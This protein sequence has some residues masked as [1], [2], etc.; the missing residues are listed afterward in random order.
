MDCIHVVHWLMAAVATRDP[1][2]GAGSDPGNRHPKQ[3]L[4]ADRSRYLGKAERR[5]RVDHPQ[6]GRHQGP[7]PAKGATQ[8]MALPSC[9]AGQGMVCQQSRH[10]WDVME[11]MLLL[12][13]N[14]CTRA[15]S[16]VKRD[17]HRW[18]DEVTPVTHPDCQNFSPD[19]RLRVSRPLGGLE[20]GSF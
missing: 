4:C 18:A 1:I 16:Y 12:H 10:L 8:G 17:F 14:G 11:L 20:S 15:P 13:R 19:R 6:G 9:E 3:P 2:P 5:N 7:P